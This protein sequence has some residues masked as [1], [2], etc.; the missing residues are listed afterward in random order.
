[1]VMKPR[2]IWEKGTP[3]NEAWLRWARQ[4][5][6]RNY[7]DGSVPDFFD[8]TSEESAGTEEGK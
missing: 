7:E 2:E 6:R 1:M 5:L 8:E 3:L 4:N